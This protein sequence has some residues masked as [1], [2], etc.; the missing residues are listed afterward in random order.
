MKP[1]EYKDNKPEFEELVDEGK[2]QGRFLILHND[3]VH[4]FDYVISTLIEVCDLE[5]TQAE[6]CTY[7]VHYTGKCDV[8][9]GSYELLQPL[10]EGLIKRE[11]NATID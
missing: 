8:K 6:Q 2:S 9:K 5:E 11:L 1:K 4:S 3:D 10:R 7:L